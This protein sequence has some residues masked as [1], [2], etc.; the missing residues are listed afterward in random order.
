MDPFSKHRNTH[1]YIHTIYS[2]CMTTIYLAMTNIHTH[3]AYTHIYTALMQLKRM[4]E[5]VD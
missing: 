2:N 1:M 4:D 3:N 5:K